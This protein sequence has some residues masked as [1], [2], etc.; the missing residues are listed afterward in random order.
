[1]KACAI[2]HGRPPFARGGARASKKKQE[3]EER[4]PRFAFFD[5]LEEGNKNLRRAVKAQLMHS[6]AATQIMLERTLTGDGELQDPATVA[7]NLAVGIYHKANGRPWKL[8]DTEPG[9]C[10]V[11]VRFYQEKATLGTKKGTGHLSRRNCV[12]FQGRVLDSSRARVRVG[13][14]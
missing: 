6:A 11:G 7:W 14:V 4:A 10:F 8:R 12:I 9:T 13:T 2:A 1:M 3:E 5:E